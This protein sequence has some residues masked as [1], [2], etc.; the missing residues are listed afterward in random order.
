MVGTKKIG[1]QAHARDGA[2]AGR[3]GERDVRA[4]L[5]VLAVASTIISETE[6]VLRGAG[7]DVRG[8]DWDLLVALAIFGPMRPA[9]LLRRSLRNLLPFDDSKPWM[10]YAGRVESGD[11][12]SSLKVDEV[13]YGQEE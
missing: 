8:N 6:E 12:D 5:G 11:P 1:E 7:A 13:I 10:R 9:E 2:L 3:L 4:M